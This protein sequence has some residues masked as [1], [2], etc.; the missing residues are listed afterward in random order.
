[1]AMAKPSSTGT[2]R[3]RNTCLKQEHRAAE[4]HKALQ[5]AICAWLPGQVNGEEHVEKTCEKTG[6]GDS[7]QDDCEEV[8]R[9]SDGAT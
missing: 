9:T 3:E 7:H 4:Q 8:L 2:W 1:M 6:S 5:Q